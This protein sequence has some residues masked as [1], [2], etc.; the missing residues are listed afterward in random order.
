MIAD[1]TL[2]GLVVDATGIETREELSLRA[3]LPARMDATQGSKVG[4]AQVACNAS[5]NIVD[6]GCQRFRVA[7]ICSIMS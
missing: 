2:E 6:D 1:Q 4:T 7:C 3:C 5:L